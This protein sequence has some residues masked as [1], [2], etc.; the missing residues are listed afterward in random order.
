MLLRLIE[1]LVETNLLMTVWRSN[2][3]DALTGSHWHLCRDHHRRPSRPPGVVA[4]A[5][6]HLNLVRRSFEVEFGLNYVQLEI[7][8]FQLG[9]EGCSR[10]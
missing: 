4:R 9:A 5:L 10:F 6:I 8:K 2:L 1:K 7:P 3:N